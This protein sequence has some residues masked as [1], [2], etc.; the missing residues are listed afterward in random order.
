MLTNY[1]RFTR[2]GLKMNPFGTL[3]HQDWLNITIIPPRLEALLAQG[4]QNIQ[5]LGDKGR[6]KSTLLRAIV[7]YLKG[8][9]DRIAYEYLP[10]GQRRFYTQ[11][12]HLDTFALDEAQRLW[13]HERARLRLYTR[14]KRLLLGS[15]VDYSRW[16]PLYTL[17][18]AELTDLEH[19]RRILTRR[20]AY[21]SL[22]TPLIHLTDDAIESLWIHFQ[23]D[24]RSMD[25]FLYDVFQ[26][27]DAPT[28]ID[29][30]FLWGTHDK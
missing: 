10:V 6:G 13:W 26:R 22:D 27:I 16:F 14:H 15:H 18:V 12:S 3:T 5:L 4:A 24:L 1:N 21:F 29:A 2:L 19:V 11:L 23:D 8:Q 7:H 17:H 9:G 30:V 28:S 25:A 20:I